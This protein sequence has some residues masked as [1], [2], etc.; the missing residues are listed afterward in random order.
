MNTESLTLEQHR[1]NFKQKRFLAMPLAGTIAWLI[2]GIGNYLFPE[3]RPLLTWI[4]AGSIFYLGIL[5]SKFTGEDL[6]GKR[7][8]K[9]HLINSL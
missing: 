2:I 1:N 6:L 7:G 5:I 4:G 8:L 9:I 3:A